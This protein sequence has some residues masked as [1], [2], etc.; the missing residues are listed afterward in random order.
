M[1]EGAR[2][3]SVYIREYIRGS[4]P[5]LSA[6]FFEENF[7][8]SYKKPSLEGIVDYQAIKGIVMDRHTTLCLAMTNETVTHFL[9]FCHFTHKISVAGPSISDTC[10]H[11]ARR[12]ACP[13]TL[14]LVGFQR[15]NIF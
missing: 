4:N 2:L 3:E 13:T 9:Q 15:I 1:A 10:E 8:H 14:D 7:S 6:R 5:L 11:L 12:H